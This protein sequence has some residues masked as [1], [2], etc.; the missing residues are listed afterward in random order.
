MGSQTAR[1]LEIIHFADAQGYVMCAEQ[2]CSPVLKLQVQVQ[3]RK[4]EM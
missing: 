4:I 3:N 2:T 1:G